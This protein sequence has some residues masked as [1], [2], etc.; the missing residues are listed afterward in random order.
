[1]DQHYHRDPHAGLMGRCPEAVWARRDRAD[2]IL[3]EPALRDGFTVRA[4]RR[5]RRDSTLSF[6][7][8]VYE[9]D[10]GF[11]AG[12]VVTVAW[13]LL[14]APRVPWVEHEAKRRPL[15]PVCPASNG[16]RKRP[17]IPEK[18][19]PSTPVPFDPP[20]AALDRALRR[21]QRKEKNA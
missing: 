4:R 14:D 11:L 6:E 7:G 20:G 15:R 21:P 3:D 18:A 10:S 16:R 2:V 17:E 5:V 19:K 1:M 9:A 8:T 13:C 12:Q